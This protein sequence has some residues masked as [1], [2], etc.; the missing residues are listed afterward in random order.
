MNDHVSLNE[1]LDRALALVEEIENL[2][3]VNLS[4]ARSAL[5]SQKRHYPVYEAEADYTFCANYKRCEWKEPGDYG[6]PE[7]YER[8]ARS[9][10]D[11]HD[12]KALSAPEDGPRLI[13]W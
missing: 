6:Q 7:G 3:A 9:F 5:E 4:T 1:E 13:R 8:I 10:L 11:H 2:H 12:L